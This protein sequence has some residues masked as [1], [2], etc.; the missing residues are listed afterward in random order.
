MA[1]HD[2][3]NNDSKYSDNKSQDLVILYSYSIFYSIY[4]YSK[5]NILP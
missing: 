5:Q 1:H 2:N 4:S 3:E